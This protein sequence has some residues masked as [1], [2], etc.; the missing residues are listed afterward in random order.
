[1]QVQFD[2]DVESESNLRLIN[3]IGEIVISRTL[4]LQSGTQ[5]I[6]LDAGTIPS[7][8]YLLELESNQQVYRTTLVKF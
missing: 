3:M 2:A 6:E 8:T 5:L 4:Q 1:M 7:G